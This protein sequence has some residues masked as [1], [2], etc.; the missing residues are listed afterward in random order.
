KTGLLFGMLGALGQVANLV[1]AR[2]GLVGGFSSLS[3]T[4]M[5]ILIALVVLWGFA[6]VRGRIGHTVRQWGHRRAFAALLGGAVAG[7]FLGIRLSLIA[8][9]QARLGIASTLMA[10]PPVILIP[11]EYLVYRRRVSRR[12]MA[13]TAVAMLGVALLFDLFST[14]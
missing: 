5:R 8:I 1:T 9:Q 10:L 6:A 4:I 11:I 3:A 12:G 14:G 2:Y 7:P 13:G